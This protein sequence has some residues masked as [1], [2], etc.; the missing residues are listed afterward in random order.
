MVHMHRGP[1]THLLCEANR[2]QDEFT[3]LF[4]NRHSQTGT[5]VSVW[6]DD[7]AFHAETDLPGIDPATLEITVTDGTQLVIR[8]ER[9]TVEPEGA[10]WL[11]QERPAGAFIREVT[12]PSLVDA[13]N[14]DARYEAG[15]LKLT[16]PKSAPVKP[17]KITVKS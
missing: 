14:V 1:F 4:G 17:R 12:L 13:D 6:A 2:I 7:N 3:R 10:V 15:V 8:G 11:R 5:T 9:T 16:L